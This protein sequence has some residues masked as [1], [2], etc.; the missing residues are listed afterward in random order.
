MS[1][2][3]SWAVIPIAPDYEASDAGRVRKIETG[4]IMKQ[5]VRKD[6]YLQVG[7]RVKGRQIFK[8][9]HIYVAFAFLP[10]D[11]SRKY[12]AHSNGVRSDNR[13]ANLRWA[14]MKENHADR[15]LHGTT[16]RGSRQGLSL[17]S[18]DEVLQ[19]R[20]LLAGGALHRDLSVRFGVC[21][22][23]IS[24]IKT[25]RSWRHL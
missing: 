17:L 10:T 21:R 20:K 16:A 1:M 5:R 18:E 3:E 15:D 9:S 24:N 14:T 8:K 22:S 13:L 19:I 23:H 2:M 11:P 4:Q 6:G 7:L 25:R 12:V